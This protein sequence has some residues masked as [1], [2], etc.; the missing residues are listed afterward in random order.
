MRGELLRAEKLAK[1]KILVR[2]WAISNYGRKTQVIKM[3]VFWFHMCICLPSPSGI[4][5]EACDTFGSARENGW[6]ERGKR[7]REESVIP[8]LLSRGQERGRRGAKVY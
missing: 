6:E 2:P 3:S 4:D 5:H 1:I 8:V 7:G